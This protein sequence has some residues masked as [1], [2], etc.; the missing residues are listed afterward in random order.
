MKLG[1]FLLGAVSLAGGYVLW[2]ANSPKVPAGITPVQ[3]FDLARYLGRWF[4]LGRVENR[5]ERGLVKTTAEYTMNAD[6]S[7]RVVNRGFNQLKRRNTHV[8]GKAKPIGAPDV[9]ALKVSFFGPFYGGYNVVAL[10][11][12]YQWAIVAGSSLKYFWVL[13]RQPVLS[14]ELKQRAIAVA[15]DIGIQPDEIYWTPQ[16]QESPTEQW[17][18]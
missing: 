7:V 15:Q 11:E 10:D 3:P 12:N 14:A 18:G 2:Q 17:V 8:T 16:E 9:A 5:F 13:S 1:K 6:G 4:E